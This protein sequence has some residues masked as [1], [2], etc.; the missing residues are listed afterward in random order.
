MSCISSQKNGKMVQGLGPRSRILW[1]GAV[2]IKSRLLG[3][4]RSTL[5]DRVRYTCKNLTLVDSEIRLR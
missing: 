2:S 5:G 4:G 3:P 1:F